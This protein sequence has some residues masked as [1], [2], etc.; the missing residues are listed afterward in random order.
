MP[1]PAQNRYLK[2]PTYLRLRT[3]LLVSVIFLAREALD[4]RLMIHN[5]PNSV[6]FRVCLLEKNLGMIQRR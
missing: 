5:I 2:T 4:V 1:R 6:R 3:R